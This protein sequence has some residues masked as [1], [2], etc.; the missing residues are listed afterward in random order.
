FRRHAGRPGSTLIPYSTCAMPVIARIVRS[1]WLRVFLVAILVAG[2]WRII[3]PHLRPSPHKPDTVTLAHAAN[4]RILRD[5]WGVPHIFG[6]TDADAAFGL[7]YAHAEDDWPTIET[8]LAAVRGRL[9]LRTLSPRARAND[10][11]VGLIHLAEITDRAY[12]SLS[13]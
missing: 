11:Y 12:A 8:V 5:R 2:A 13:P 1:R 10:Y 9:S 4:V 3:R 7:A 6:K